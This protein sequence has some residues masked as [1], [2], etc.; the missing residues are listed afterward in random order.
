MN[1]TNITNGLELVLNNTTKI[2]EK[3]FSSSGWFYILAGEKG[4]EFSDLLSNSTKINPTN[5]MTGEWIIQFK[6]IQDMDEVE[7][8]EEIEALEEWLDL[9]TLENIADRISYPAGE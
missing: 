4:I 9:F 7:V 8:G 3:I 6:C 1:M 2:A 5:F